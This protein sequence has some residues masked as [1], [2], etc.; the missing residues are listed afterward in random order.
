[1]KETGFLSYTDDNT[2]YRT[3]D[4]IDEVMKLL[5]RHYKMLLKEFSDN[6]TKEIISES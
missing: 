3:T 2:S 6:Q 1:M 4:T 5:E